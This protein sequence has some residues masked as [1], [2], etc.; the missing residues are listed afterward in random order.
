MLRF[1]AD[2]NAAL[3]AIFEMRQSDRADTDLAVMVALRSCQS[4]TSCRTLAD[5]AGINRHAGD[6]RTVACAACA[7]NIELPLTRVAREV[8]VY[9]ERANRKMAY[10]TLVVAL[11][12]NDGLSS[13]SMKQLAVQRKFRVGLG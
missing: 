2:R 12:S 5:V 13:F 4:V 1:R 9:S 6:A 7:R 10:L 11:Y 3:V 8:N